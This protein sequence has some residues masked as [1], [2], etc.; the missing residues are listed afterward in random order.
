MQLPNSKNERDGKFK[1]SSNYL[2]FHCF[3][4]AVPHLF[5]LRLP[6]PFSWFGIAKERNHFETS[7]F[8][9]THD[10]RAKL[11][12]V[13]SPK[14]MEAVASEMHVKWE[15]MDHGCRLVQI[16]AIQLN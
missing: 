9:L 5:I 4:H 1:L 13:V 3:D 10:G 12:E 7:N 11:S 14:H 15:T 8:P 16:R 6:S 2:R